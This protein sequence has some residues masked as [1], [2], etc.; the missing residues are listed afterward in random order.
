MKGILVII[1]VLVFATAGTAAE[2]FKWTDERGVVHFTNVETSVPEERKD[3]VERRVTPG[4][5]AAVPERTQSSR[6]VTE[7]P[8]TGYDRGKEFWVNRTNEAKGR[9]SRA[10]GKYEQLRMEY[11]KTYADWEATTSLAKRDEYEKKMESL[12]VDLR[13][14]GE[15]VNRA[16]QMLEVTLPE[17]A[18]RAGVPAEWVQ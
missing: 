2:Y 14:Q 15:D 10:Q 4:G 7:E 12:K 16:K 18:A 6:G 1:A 8:Q 5:K 13:R 17:E 11:K 9:L 3:D